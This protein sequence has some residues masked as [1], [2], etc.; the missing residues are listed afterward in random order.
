[1]SIVEMTMSAVPL[2]ISRKPSTDASA[3]NAFLGSTKHQIAPSANSTPSNAWIHRQLGAIAIV[4]NSFRQPTAKTTPMMTPIVVIDRSLNRSTTSEIT[5]HSN[6]V[7][8]NTHH[9]PDTSWAIS[10]SSRSVIHRTPVSMV[11]SNVNGGHGGA[12]GPSGDAGR[13]EGR[14]SPALAHDL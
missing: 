3:Q 5:N 12:R 1:R 2:K 9:N 13:D 10:R 11:G 6:P 7:S 4:M 14:A 8:R